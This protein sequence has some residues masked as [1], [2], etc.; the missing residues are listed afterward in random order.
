MAT[1]RFHPVFLVTAT[2][3]ADAATKRQPHRAEHLAGVAR[4]LADGTALVA[5]AMA[6]LSASVLVLRV[7]DELAALAVA[8][9]DVYWRTGVWT[10]VRVRAYQAATPADLG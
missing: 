10:D 4:L 9:S 7:P 3:C 2:Y 6:D 5:G 1:P 8:H